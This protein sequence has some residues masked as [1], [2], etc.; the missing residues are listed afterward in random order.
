MDGH[1][2][3]PENL[4]PF[5]PPSRN[6][7]SRDPHLG[8]SIRLH[9]TPSWLTC[10]GCTGLRC[11][12][13]QAVSVSCRWTPGPQLTLQSAGGIRAVSGVVCARCRSSN[14]VCTSSVLL[15]CRKTPAQPPR[16]RNLRV[17]CKPR[18]HHLPS[19]CSDRVG[20]LPPALPASRLLADGLGSLCRTHAVVHGLLLCL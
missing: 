20:L 11:A 2:Q 1:Q 19:R 17:S 14:T 6:R 4:R 3:N 16:G 8:K 15:A 10:P 9:P 18:R 13:W 12:L 5:S 7:P